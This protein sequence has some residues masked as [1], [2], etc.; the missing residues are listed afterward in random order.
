MQKLAALSAVALAMTGA[1]FAQGRLFAVA[2]NRTLYDID[3]MTGQANVIGQV[4]AN[5]GTTGGL[6]YDA[7]TGTMYLTSTSNDSLY[8]LDINTG[9]A[10]LIGAYGDSGIVMHGIEWDSSTGTLYGASGGGTTAGNFYT[11][12]TSTG[13]ATLVG[14]NGLTSFTNLGYNS[15]TDVMYA[16]N[17]GTDSFYSV[18][19]A[20]GAATLIGPLLTSTNPNSL[21]YNAANGLMYMIDNTTDNLYTINLSTGEATVVGSVG[22]SNILGLVWVPTPGAASLLGLGALGAARRRR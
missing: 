10:T 13:A 12:S 16:T 7:S 6:A 3:M 17:S 5:A 15:T 20:T 14:S 1:A 8:T 9:A 22:S 2:S 19:R 4:S 18:N 11:V 21:A